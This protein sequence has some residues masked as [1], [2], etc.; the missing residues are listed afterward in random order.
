M[1]NRLIEAFMDQIKAKAS[2]ISGKKPL[3]VDASYERN[4][5]SFQRHQQ[6]PD[7]VRSLTL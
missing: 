5:K 6:K 7:R 3:F 4:T 2:N 1:K